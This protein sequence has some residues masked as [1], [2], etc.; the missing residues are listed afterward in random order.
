MK[1]SLA[2][3]SL[4]NFYHR[5]LHRQM[6]KVTLL[7]FASIKELCGGKNRECLECDSSVLQELMEILFAKY[8][9]IQSL[10]LQH[11]SVLVS[12]NQEYV[13]DWSQCFLNDGDEV[14][15]IPPV[16]G[17]WFGSIRLFMENWAALE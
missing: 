15:L 3:Y 16:S 4:R 7:Y 9:G 12:V 13:Q 14:A 6:V 11:K 5:R 8:S 10:L 2:T 1:W 17:G